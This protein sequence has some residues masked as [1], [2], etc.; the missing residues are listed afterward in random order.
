VVYESCAELLEVSPII[1]GIFGLS[2]L[3]TAH[4]AQFV[5]FISQHG[6]KRGVGEQYPAVEVLHCDSQGS[7]LKKVTEQ[8]RS[9]RG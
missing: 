6:T 1:F 3:G 5:L 9:G 7:L 4:C 2:E 8:L